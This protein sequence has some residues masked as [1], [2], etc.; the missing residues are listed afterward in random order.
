MLKQ[1]LTL[2]AFSALL[3]IP[4]RAQDTEFSVS[5]PV[6][7][8][9]GALYS[10]R[11]QLL[12]P[13]AAP[14]APAFRAM[15]YPTVQIGSHWFG[16]AAVQ[17]RSTPYFYYDAFWSEKEIYTDA[18][19]AYVGYSL[20]KARTSMVIKAGKLSSA[21]GSFP[22][23]YD[24]A[25][26]ALLD[27]PLSYI[28]DLPIRPNQ[29]PCGTSDLLKQYYGFAYFGC[30][31]AAG[32]AAG[33]VP[34]T[35][36]GLPGAE[37]DVSTGP[38]DGRF[39][40]TSGSPANPQNLSLAG[41]YLQWTAGGGYT[42]HQ[43]FRVGLS[44][45]RGPYLDPIVAPLLPVG[46]TVRNFPASGIGTDVQ[47]AKGRFSASG[48]LQR[49][50][51]DFPAF[52]AQ[53]AITAGYTE[54]KTQLTPRLFVAGRGGFLYA[55]RVQDKTGVSADQFAPYI[56]T[57]EV[58]AG[59]WVTRNQ[60]L[61]GGYEWMRSEGETGRKTDVLGVQYVVQIHSLGWAF[62]R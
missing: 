34:V 57:Y 37:I 5:M 62:N 44:G 33:P 17:V 12:T 48:E 29:L 53:P 26:N 24:D 28:T 56:R 39:Q 31:G 46:T 51:F 1:V 3:A 19:Q 15:F 55:G 36:Y 60:L 7:L 22:L 27:Q 42:I 54:L 52:T 61:K 43:G 30:G 58:A 18:L 9:A 40:L 38:V 8:S 14:A 32:G 2:S 4:S 35:L 50:Q 16:Y 13:D 11:L 23:H 6:T 21:F 20:H 59:F 10:E 49:F 25:E 45:F 47:W 41:T